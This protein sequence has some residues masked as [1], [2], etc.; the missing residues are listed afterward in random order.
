MAKKTKAAAKRAAR[1]KA[2]EA[3]IAAIRAE[4][5]AEAIGEDDEAGAEGEE[6]E[7][8]T[9]GEEEELGAEGEEGEAAAEGEEEEME[10]EG[11]EEEKP[12]A[13][14]S[15]RRLAIMG[16]PEAEE[17]RS[18]ARSLADQGLS[19]KQAQAALRAAKRTKALGSNTDASLA[20]RPSGTGGKANASQ[21]LVADFVAAV[22]PSRLRKKPGQ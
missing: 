9:E 19:V 22:G 17:Q 11:E 10:A 8:E 1:I 21:A 7:V 2:L 13:K 6:E 12:A 16:L 5:E 14:T 18:F 3:Q 15:H 4:D 20:T